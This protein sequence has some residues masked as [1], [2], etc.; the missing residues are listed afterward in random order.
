MRLTEAKLKQ[1]I[2]EEYEMMLFE[3][4]IME[5]MEEIT[6]ED[7]RDVDE[8][9]LDKM[10]LREGGPVSAGAA[11]IGGVLSTPKILMLIGKA[12]RN[13]HKTPFIGKMF[14][15]LEDEEGKPKDQQSTRKKFADFIYGLGDKGHTFFIKGFSIPVRMYFK[16]KA[17]K[18]PDFEMP[19]E[20]VIKAVGE[21]LMVLVIAVCASIGIGSVIKMLMSGN[22]GILAAAE[23]ALI[24]VKGVEL[25]EYGAKITG[26]A[27]P[28]ALKFLVTPHMHHGEKKDSGEKK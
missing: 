14:K 19:D 26:T 18:D 24:S 9:K 11:L 12:L 3:N 20:K 15:S 4:S 10:V 23:S 5:G 1:L 16:Y 22:A 7:M 17:K 21:G 2:N 6:E 27:I 8:A 13:L 25:G 28:L